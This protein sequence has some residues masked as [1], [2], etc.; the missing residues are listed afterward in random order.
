MR[1][2][3]VPCEILPVCPVCGGP[4]LL[5]AT[6]VKLKICVC[7]GCGTSLTVPEEAWSEALLR[8]ARPG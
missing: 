3:L 8:R 1:D 2:G 4:L 5:A 6:H 7:R